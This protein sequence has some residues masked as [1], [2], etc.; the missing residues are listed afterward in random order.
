[1]EI[2]KKSLLGKAIIYNEI[3]ILLSSL[4]VFVAM[5]F[6]IFKDMD[7]RVPKLLKDSG[8][9]LE[10]SYVNYVSNIEKFVEK[11]IN[12]GKYDYQL[13][14]I[15]ELSNVEKRYRS[16]SESRVGTTENINRLSN[17]F[18]SY[19]AQKLRQNE[20]FNDVY[21]SLS[22]ADYNGNIVAE[23]LDWEKENGTD[24]SL[25][26]A[27]QKFK[28]NV[29]LFQEGKAQKYFDLVENK[30][31][32]LLR[33]IIRLEGDYKNFRYIVVSTRIDNDFLNV[34]RDYVELDE[35]I[36]LFVLYEDIYV[37]G[38]LDI[39]KGTVMLKS[40]NEN[41]MYVRE[42]IEGNK[43]FRLSYT[44][45]KDYNGEIIGYFG[46]AL[47]RFILI[48]DNISYYIVT[49]SVILFLMFIFSMVFSKLYSNLFTPLI[50]L[51][52]ISNRVTNGDLEVKWRVRAQGE[53]KIL[54]ESMKKMVKTIKLNQEDLELQNKKLREYILVFK[55]VENLLINIHSENDV[56][57]IISSILKALTSSK[58]F[59]FARAIYLE[60]D[61]ELEILKGKSSS[62]NSGLLDENSKMFNL[63]S[64]LKLQTESLDKIVKLITV[65]LDDNLI[66]QSV[67]KN[68]TMY[69]NDRGFKYNLGSELL[70]SLGLNNFILVPIFTVNKRYGLIIVDH[71][72]TKK[73]INEEDIE[74]FN[75]LSLHMTIYLKNKELESEKLKSEKHT[76][77]SYLSNKILKELQV[78]MANIKDIIAN[79]DNE[80][81]ISKEKI[82]GIDKNIN[83]IIKLSSMVLD[84]SD[85]QQYSF[86]KLDLKDIIDK[87]IDN[88]KDILKDTMID[89][90]KLY[91]HKEYVIGNK[92]KLEKVISN[93]L[94]N[95]V[96]AVDKVG[97][98][99]NI[100]TKSLPNGIRIKISD[101]GRGIESK[102]LKRIFDPFVSLR[103]SSGLGLAIAK[104]I[105]KEHNGEISVRSEIDNGTEVRITLN[106][107]KEE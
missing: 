67:L 57:K 15:D 48:E 25:N 37:S 76:T 36:R 106:I 39:A 4:I 10:I 89:L 6:V 13:R 11:I 21:F 99:I 82:Y 81:N 64:R 62:I 75:L 8:K 77:I 80:G 16:F 46:L 104:K 68:K 55:M 91:T 83:K 19:L 60:F 61:S 1:M 52:E 45:V 86:E 23:K 35:N 72:V 84:Y 90:S 56:D 74:M 9:N 17:E 103:N 54:V 14:K 27:L 18:L 97:G 31:E 2:Y 5:S 44:P 96:E 34:L 66:A 58:G 59:N 105:I 26:S 87:S 69:Y 42:E 107:Y 28:I 33:M 73:R 53:I 30:N 88:C 70:I 22:L 29:S 102:N 78:P 101:N 41:D 51:T 7:D 38:Q 12:D 47:S 24:Y 40:K 94:I 32:L 50:Q 71:S 43:R 92:D 49:F 98:R 79:Y 65:D 63:T 100:T 20:Y 93:I 95:A 3:A 85:T